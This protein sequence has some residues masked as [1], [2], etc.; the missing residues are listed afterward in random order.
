MRS[1]EI[2]EAEGLLNDISKSEILWAESQRWD[3][4]LAS[5]VLRTAYRPAEPATSSM[6]IAL[7]AAGIYRTGA[8][9]R[10][11]EAYTLAL[12]LMS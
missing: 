6:D 1:F 5:T 12:Q 4:W 2:Q 9:Y 8:E 10:I 3:T 7:R 11:F